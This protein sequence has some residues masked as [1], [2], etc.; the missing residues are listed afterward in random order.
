MYI[1]DSDPGIYLDNLTPG[2]SFT[3]QELNSSNK[4]VAT[5]GTGTIS[6]NVSQQ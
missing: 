4:V 5:I 6:E 3:I 1:G 2:V